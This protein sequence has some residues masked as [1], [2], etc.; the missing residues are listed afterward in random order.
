MTLLSELVEELKIQKK[1]PNNKVSLYEDTNLL[2]INKPISFYNFQNYVVISIITE[3]YL[4]IGM[5]YTKNNIK[6]DI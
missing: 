1:I 6:Y 5:I 4:S 3:D 2:D